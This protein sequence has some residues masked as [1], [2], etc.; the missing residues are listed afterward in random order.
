[1]RSVR[2]GNAAGF[3]GDNLDAPRLLAQAGRLDYLTLEY[4]AELTLSILAHQ[5]TKRPD[6]GFVTD[7][8]L[9]VQSLLPQLSADQPMKI[10]TNGGGMNP[11]ACAQAT[12]KV[13]QAAGLGQYRIAT[14]SGDD[15]MPR[16]DELVRL[17]E[18]FSH[19]DDE[20]PLGALRERIASAN[21]YLG[22]AGIVAALQQDAQIVL[23]G[24]IA[25]AALVVGPAVF[26]FD[27]DWQDWH[28]LG[29]ATVAGH[30]IECGA[31]VTGGMYS[32]WEPSI[33]LSHVGYP[34]AILEENGD[35]T[36]TKPS[37][38]GGVVSVGTVA[39]QLVY[40]IGDPRRYMTPDVIADFANVRLT[41]VSKDE[42]HVTGGTGTEAP[43]TYKVSLSYYD[44]FATS[45]SIVVTG[46]NARE[47]AD[48]C[49]RI[50]RDR[51]QSSGYRLDA[52]YWECLGSGG[53]LPGME[54]WQGNGQEV[55]LRIAARDQ[56]REAIDRL[57]RELAPLVTSGPPGVTGYTESRARSR[58]VIS[59]WPSVIHRDRIE[60]VV[61]VQTAEE[62]LA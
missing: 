19:F 34:I 27:W 26:E 39:E 55:V 44:G 59:Y 9:V 57:T 6:A 11:A 46:Q 40:E 21:A 10:I 53:T 58:P 61:K 52:Y 42:V 7:V 23:T 37:G 8:P 4:L 24:R 13:L 14:V 16:L 49:A 47:K 62:W 25:D 30:L 50:V 28:R 60:P 20:R 41:Q 2:I 32:D 22:A 33:D 12:A 1:M 43:S 54:I 17:G 38:T 36:I 3:W 29:A 35:S 56:R 15:L 48:C 31:Q 5:R 18:S 51:V 45:G